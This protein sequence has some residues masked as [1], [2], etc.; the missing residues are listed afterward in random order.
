VPGFVVAV[1]R[2][3]FTVAGVGADRTTVTAIKARELGRHGIVVGDRVDIVGDVSGEDGVLARIV[4]RDPR[5][6]ALRRS[7]DDENDAERIVVANADRLAIVT[8]LAEP[9]PNPRFID[10]CLVAAFDAGLD[11]LIIATKADLA[12]PDA[13]AAAY[14]PLGVPVIATRYV[15]KERAGDATA[16]RS[17]QGLGDVLSEIRDRIT[18][19]I[20]S[21]GVGKSTLVNAMVPDALRSVGIVNA[22]TGRGRHTSTSAVA[23]PLPQGGWIIDTPGIR[24]FGLAHVDADHFVHAFPDV[25]EAADACPRGCTHESAEAG[26]ALDAWADDPDRVARVASIRRLYSSR[27]AADSQ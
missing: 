20:G 6:R 11:A 15:S 21:S 16:G 9:E 3:R 23:L 19:L 8:S 7:A 10:R 26:C 24:T 13:L 5:E 4:R 1:D 12:S 17:I 14:R 25:A 22:V 18:V 2:G 27:N